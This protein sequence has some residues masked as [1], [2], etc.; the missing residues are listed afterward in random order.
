MLKTINVYAIAPEK[1]YRAI[2]Y[3]FS[4][5]DTFQKRKEQILQCKDLYRIPI[6]GMGVCGLLLNDCSVCLG[7]LMILYQ[8]AWKFEQGEDIR[9]LIHMAGS[10]LSGMNSCSFWSAAE[11]KIV[12]GKIG[13]FSDAYHPL[14][15]VKRKRP[16]FKTDIENITGEL[17]SLSEQL[18]DFYIDFSIE[19]EQEE[20]KKQC[21]K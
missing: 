3:F 21:G 4:H 5:L 8:A 9:Y 2:E 17:R 10:P 7:E 18:M 13:C 15:E 1:D 12:Y 14:I 16:K 6:A 19:R 20:R 11:Q